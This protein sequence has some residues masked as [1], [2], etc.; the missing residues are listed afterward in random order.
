MTNEGRDWGGLR[1]IL[2]EA[3][4]LDNEERTHPL[5]DCPLCGTPLNENARGE[6]NCPMG[7]FR[8]PAGMTRNQ[9]E[10]R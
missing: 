7:H 5:V 8:A 10:G 2:D 4:A 3:R 1:S 9:A 6:K